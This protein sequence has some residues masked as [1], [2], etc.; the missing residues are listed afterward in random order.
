[1]PCLPYHLFSKPSICMPWQNWASMIKFWQGALRPKHKENG[2]QTSGFQYLRNLW[3]L[4]YGW[5]LCR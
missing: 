4:L 1:M 2:D 3:Q 5:D